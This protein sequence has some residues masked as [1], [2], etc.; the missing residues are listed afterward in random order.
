MSGTILDVL[1]FFNV[2]SPIVDELWTTATSMKCFHA[3]PNVISFSKEAFIS[4]FPDMNWQKYQRLGTIYGYLYRLQNI[5]PRLVD[6]MPVGVSVE[7]RDILVVK[8][9]FNKN[10]RKPAIFLEAGKT[11]KIHPPKKAERL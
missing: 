7:G 11:A 8:I 1:A 3:T 4:D 9:G 6:V 10:Y 2:P 5:Y